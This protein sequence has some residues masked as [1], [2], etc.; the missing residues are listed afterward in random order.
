MILTV[1]LNVAIDKKYIVENFNINHVN[2]VKEC[3]YSAGGKGLNVSR[4]AAIAGEEVLATGFIGG[5]SGDYVVQELETQNIKNDFVKVVGE[6]RSCI[7]IY[8]K[9]NHTQTEFLEPGVTV[10]EKNKKE[11]LEK[12]TEL[13]KKSKVITISGSVPKGIDSSFYKELIQ[14]G[15]KYEKKVLLDTSGILLEE[16]LKSNPTLIKP[17][18]DEI[19]ALIGRDV[20]DR[21]DLIQIASDLCKNGIDVVVVSLGSEGSLI[22]C[23]EG[24]YQAIVPKIAAV[25]T[26]GCGDSMLA[27]FAIGFERELS[28]IQ[29]IKLASAISAANALRKETGFFVNEDMQNILPK[30]EVNKLSV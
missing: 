13:A 16:A 2:R 17:N 24:V 29:T 5:H 7:N 30:I 27:G 4:V 22:A 18:R 3:I 14:T 12:F 23:E 10:T 6:S 26:V 20:K 8:D 25:N 9:I 21:K 11:M 1:T 19:K 15:K 28:M